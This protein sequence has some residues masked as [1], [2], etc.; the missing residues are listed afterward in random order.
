M[1]ALSPAERARLIESIVND[2]PDLARDRTLLVQ[3]MNAKGWVE[4]S[5][6]VF[7]Y[8]NLLP[9]ELECEF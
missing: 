6:Q 4:E 8:L 7:E 5:L 9:R 3:F 2:H 1:V